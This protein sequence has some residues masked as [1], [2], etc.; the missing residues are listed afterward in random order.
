MSRN[1]RHAR[2]I[3]DLV[4]PVEQWNPLTTA[5]EH[6]ITYIDIASVDADLKQV[7]APKRVKSSVA[8]SR[9][10]QRVR[11]NDV[12]VSTVRPNLNAVAAVPP[13]LDGATASTGFC[14]LRPSERLLCDRY[15]FNWVRS[16]DFVRSMVRL[17]TGASY[18]A[19]SDRIVCE[20][21]IP[22]PYPDDP[23]RSMGEQK[24]IAAILDKADA[25]RRRRHEAAR[26]TNQLIPSLFYDMFGDPVI[27]PHGYQTAALGD[28]A[29]FCSGG[30]PSKSVPEFWTGRVPWVS[31]KDMKRDELFDATNHISDAAVNEA[32]LRILAP[33]AV[34]VVVRGMILAHTVPIAI[35]RVPLTINQ[36]MRAFVPRGRVSSEFLSW[37]LRAQHGR[38]LSLVSNAAHGTKRFESQDLQNLRVPVPPVGMQSEFVARVRRSTLLRNHR[39]TMAAEADAMF[40]AL[41]QRAFREGL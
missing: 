16:P 4:E 9:A 27:N 30:T 6:E 13:D 15:L 29:D 28:V 41:A 12:L 35:N 22:L 40:N 14:V 8:P 11:A 3:G 36:D 2:P 24:R 31:P 1:G 18:P 39:E 32:N 21:E 33:G 17:A 25:I 20:S 37:S 23:K 19:V 26:L 5:D 7:V 34:L 38:L 10:R